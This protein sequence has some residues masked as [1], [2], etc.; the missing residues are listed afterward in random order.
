MKESDEKIKEN[1]YRKL[2]FDLSRF[3]DFKHCKYFY[4]ISFVADIISEEDISIDHL[5]HLNIREMKTKSN[6]ENIN[7]GS[8][9]FFNPKYHKQSTSLNMESELNTSILNNIIKTENK[10]EN[11]YFNNI[12]ISSDQF[13]KRIGINL[14][15]AV[16]NN[17][18]LIN[19]NSQNPSYFSIGQS[20]NS[21]RN[22]SSTGNSL[23]N[24]GVTKEGNVS[25]SAFSSD[26]NGLKNNN[27][28]TTTNKASDNNNIKVNK[29]VPYQQINLLTETYKK[30]KD[31]TSS[32]NKVGEILKGFKIIGNKNKYTAETDV[33]NSSLIQ[34]QVN[35]EKS[36]KQLINTN[37]SVKIS[38]FKQPR[39]NHTNHKNS[40]SIG[41]DGVINKLKGDD[42]AELF[43]SGNEEEN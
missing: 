29:K 5:Q 7:K 28:Y 19:S 3:K 22:L 10:I 2:F 13:N 24:S 12:N 23:T 31:P 8:R 35:K 40:V 11:Y 6:I 42:M 4:F 39:I 21:L 41:I 30:K 1:Y 43:F 36:G 33:A 26:L 15:M 34:N 38:P 25:V 18:K 20:V 17:N 32:A 37:M 14:G 16:D 27:N 9:N